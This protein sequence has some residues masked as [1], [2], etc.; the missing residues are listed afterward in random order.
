MKRLKAAARLAGKTLPCPFCKHPI[1]V[2]A[3]EVSSEDAAYQVLFDD[4][5][6]AETDESESAASTE[7]APVNLPEPFEHR[8]RQRT[9]PQ[10]LPRVP[11]PLNQAPLASNETPFWLRHLH[12]VLALAMIPLVVSLLH[13]DASRDDIAERFTKTIDSMP[14]DTQQQVLQ[15]LEDVEAGKASEEDVFRLLPRGKLVGAFLPRR[16]VVH[17]L[18]GLAATVAFMTFFMLLAA[19]QSAKPWHLLAV[20]LFTATIGILLLLI[21]QVIASITE[22]VMFG[23]GGGIGVIIFFVLKLIGFSYRAALDPDNGFVLS[24]IGF[25]LGVGLCEEAVKLL[26]ILFRFRQPNDYSWRNAFLWGLASGAGFGISEG[27]T[28]CSDFYNGITGPGIYVVRFVSCVALHAL[29]TGSAAV[30]LHQYQHLLHREQ[31][32]FE[33]IFPIL[34]YILVPMILHGLYDTFLKKEMNL[35]A[36]ITAALSFVFLAVQIYRLRDV[37]D[38]EANEAMLREYSR[39]RRAQWQS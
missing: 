31:R 12:W 4:S 21:V 15:K 8:V 22:N 23:G 18:I 35:G 36:L 27:I 24:F 20:G 2:P 37:D 3:T 11:E 26:P 38:A 32:W 9:V 1:Q 30:M 6:P 5:P 29:W 16:T 25:T 19:D 10:A 17:W 34:I 7:Q 33:Y 14:P 28:Y 13:K 39:R